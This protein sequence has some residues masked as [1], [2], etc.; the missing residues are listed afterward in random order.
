MMIGR[1]TGDHLIRERTRERT[2][3]DR[4]ESLRGKIRER[5]IGRIGR[6]R[7]RER[8]RTGGKMRDRI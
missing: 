7:G 2:R 1:R 3:G 5:M 4:T 6:I 8:D